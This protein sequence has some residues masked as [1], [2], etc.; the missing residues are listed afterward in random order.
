MK[1]SAFAFIG[2]AS[3]AVVLR[4]LQAQQPTGPSFEVA[5]VKPSNPNPTSPLGM[6]PM[7]LPSA[8]GRFSATNVPL[9]LLIRMAYG[10]HDFQIEGGPSWQMSQ[11]FDITAKA[12]DGF[13]GGPQEIVP[14]V[15]TLLADRFKLK[16]HTE[17]REMPVSALVIAREDGKLGPRLKPSTSDCSNAQA[18]AQKLADAIA[19][20]GP[21]ALAGMLPKPGE[22]R[23]CA[24]S[25]MI[26]AEGFGMRADGQP[27]TMI[28]QLLTQVTGRIVTDK[29]GLTGLYD[30]EIRFDPQALLQVA[31]QAGVNLPA[32]NLPASDSP[33][34]LTAL[35]E[36]L[37]LKLESERGPVEVLVI[38]NAE[39]PISD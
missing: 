31:S 5:S 19:K 23:T 33:S 35:R 34:L 20:G 32:V 1:K 17:T 13:T 11:R 38:D 9:R 8:N 16:V 14:M 4:P 22:K 27:L 26:G 39:M 29:T 36:D 2:I 28:V 30:W 21:G 12:E 10:V 15:K 3:M 25:P 7:I 37:G 18:E 6:I 24:V